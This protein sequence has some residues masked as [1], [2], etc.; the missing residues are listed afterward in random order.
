MGFVAL[1]PFVRKEVFSL[2][3]SS[4]WLL[5]IAG[6]VSLLASIFDF[7]ALREGKISIIE[8]IIG[9]ELPLTVF[10]SVTLGREG[11]TLP[12]V[13]SILLVF[14][15]VALV[16]TTHARYRKAMF[17]KGV[18]FGFV[19]ALGIALSSFLVGISSK[20]I[21]PLMTIWFVHSLIALACGL[22][23]L[24]QG[25]LRS[26]FVDLRHHGKL[27]IGQSVLDN[28]AWVAFAF[29]TS[30]IPIS[31]ANTISGSYV[32]LAVLLGL[33][34]SKERLRFHQAVGLAM[35]IV[36]ILALSRVS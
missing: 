10:L 13:L 7:E 15:G 5:F 29:A 22:F 30:L 25:R 14:F 18:I 21:S 16:V 23:L 11:L 9:L 3:A 17:E 2:P 28:G 20:A 36:G 32:A 4:V 35:A 27:I 33:F 31:I 8:P 12:Q 24:A 34:V 6:I 1:F 26:L 19:G